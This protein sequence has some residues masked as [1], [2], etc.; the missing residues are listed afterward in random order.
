[1]HIR[2]REINLL[3]YLHPQEICV[4]V[5]GG[6]GDVGSGAGLVRGRGFKMNDQHFNCFA[7]THKVMVIHRQLQGLVHCILSILS[8]KIYA[9]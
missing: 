5:G 9:N 1:M 4:E 2:L 8:S 7:P 3:T 6:S